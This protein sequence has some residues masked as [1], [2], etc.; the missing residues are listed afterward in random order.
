MEKKNMYTKKLKFKPILTN[1][2]NVKQIEEC[3]KFNKIIQ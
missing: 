3:L 1:K 2:N